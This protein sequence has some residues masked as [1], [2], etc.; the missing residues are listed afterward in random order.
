VREQAAKLLGQLIKVAQRLVAP[1]VSPI[2]RAVL[3]KLRDP[4]P[5]ACSDQAPC[6]PPPSGALRVPVPRV[7]AWFTASNAGVALRGCCAVHAPPP[8][9]PRI[10]TRVLRVH[11]CVS[12]CA[13]AR[14]ALRVCA[15]VASCVLATLGE[16]SHVGAEEIRPYLP[17]LVPHILDALQDQTSFAKQEVCAIC[18]CGCGA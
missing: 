18:A 14:V 8:C 13:R 2:L 17:E 11:G 15:G 5:G 12:A 9:P 4:N 1:Y 10:P 7:R 6:Q 16:L 3:T